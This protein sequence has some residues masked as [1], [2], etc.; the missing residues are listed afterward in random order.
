MAN[1]KKKKSGNDTVTKLAI[2]T[3]IL[4]LLNSLITLLMK[5]IEWLNK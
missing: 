2:A 3:A 5:I 4:A 1:R